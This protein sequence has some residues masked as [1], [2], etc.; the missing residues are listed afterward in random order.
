MERK[1][2]KLQI[3]KGNIV[4]GKKGLREGEELLMGHKIGFSNSI[5]RA[6]KWRD[7]NRKASARFDVEAVVL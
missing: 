7:E 4:A 3:Y 2:C 1:Q 6:Q 5:H